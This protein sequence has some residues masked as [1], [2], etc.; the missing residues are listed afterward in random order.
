ML[1]LLTSSI[2]LIT[3][4]SSSL[5]KSLAAIEGPFS[6]SS[7]LN[8]PFCLSLGSV[9]WCLLFAFVTLLNSSSCMLLLLFPRY[10]KMYTDDNDFNDNA[11]QL[12]LISVIWLQLSTPLKFKTKTKIF[13][14]TYEMHPPRLFFLFLRPRAVGI[15]HWIHH[16]YF[17]CL[18]MHF[19]IHV[20]L[21]SEPIFV[22]LKSIDIT[23]TDTLQIQ[24][25]LTIGDIESCIFRWKKNIIFI[26]Y[27][28]IIH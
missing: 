28:I 20:R 18:E 17:P 16:F 9:I 4:M 7:L 3:T 1:V 25:E 19:L 24:T 27:Y 10:P 26:E 21:P 2:Q 13:I 11:R 15:H 8:I 23:F 6:W 22:F 12:I 5:E 14:R